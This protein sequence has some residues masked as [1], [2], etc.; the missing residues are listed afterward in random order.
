MTKP[1]K[2]KAA[3]TT[4]AP[5]TKTLITSLAMAATIGG[6]AL[7]ASNETPPVATTATAQPTTTTM[8]TSNTVPQPVP[9][10]DL[11]PIPTIIPPPD[12]TAPL[13]APVEPASNPPAPTAAPAAPVAPAAPAP[14][15]REV[16]APTAAP[17]PAAPAPVT[18][19][20]SSR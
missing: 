10:L 18:S 8:T 19:T 17:A 5:D 7:F 13:T 2:K 3:T 9:A 11:P 20:Q 1:V 16:A 6:W 14:V 4:G 12:R 15:L